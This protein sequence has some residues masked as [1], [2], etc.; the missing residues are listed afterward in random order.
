[1]K[2]EYHQKE[3][4][5]FA[6]KQMAPVLLHAA[7]FDKDISKVALVEPYSSFRSI[8][9]N[10][11]YN[12]HF[13]QSTVPAS[14]GVYDLPDLAGS[15]APNKLLMVDVTDGTGNDKNTNDVNQD[16]S[17]IKGAYHFKNA[18]SKL[19]ITSALSSENLDSILKTWLEK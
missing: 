19:Q 8:V 18:D 7:A 4:Y 14:I 5:G 1:L 3:I 9:M 6:K 10:R 11:L 12:P 13:I 2:N 15:L 16:L 17:V